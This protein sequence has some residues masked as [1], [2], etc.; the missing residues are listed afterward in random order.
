LIIL[1]GYVYVDTQSRVVER[2]LTAALI[3]EDDS[4]WD[5]RLKSQLF[6]VARGARLFQQQRKKARD[7]STGLDVHLH[8]RTRLPP[9][10]SPYGDD[11]DVL[12]LG[13]CGV[14]FP[15]SSRKL[16]NSRIIISND[17]T[18]PAP[19]HLRPHPFA[20]PDVLGS[21]YPPHTRVVH[22]P[23]GG[24]CSF[25]YAISQSG[26]RKILYEFGVKGFTEQ[27]DVA[28]GKF[29]DGTLR[30]TLGGKDDRKTAHAVPNC[31]TT[32]PTLFSHRYGREVE[33]DIEIQGGGYITKEQTKYIRW[34]MRMNLGK[35]V[36]GETDYVD[37]WPDAEGKLPL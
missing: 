15:D 33:S 36:N 3:L 37:Q 35:M 9:S 4:D 26:A 8:D 21:L 34:S 2:N 25:A 27:F 28:L 12:F 18:V 6:T 22:H 32:Q 29:C 1:K 20:N 19:Q 17:E 24:I 10:K 11:W 7:S 5:I 30:E 31:I 13:H 23:L 16:P 14:K